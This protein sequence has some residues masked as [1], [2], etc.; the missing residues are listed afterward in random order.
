MLSLEMYFTH[1]LIIRI[2]FFNSEG[3]KTNV[4][5]EVYDINW[6]F[7]I[8]NIIIKKWW[9]TDFFSMA[10]CHHGK[11]KGFMLRNCSE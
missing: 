11:K 5:F 4:C 3:I 10:N 9:V 8:C 7:S 6:M 1:L 2:P